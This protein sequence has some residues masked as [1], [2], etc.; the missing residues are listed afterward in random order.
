MAVMIAATDLG[1]GIGTRRWWIR[2]R[3]VPFSA[4]RTG[5]RWLTCSASDIPLIVR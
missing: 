5:T 4:S 3:H 1:I 2:K